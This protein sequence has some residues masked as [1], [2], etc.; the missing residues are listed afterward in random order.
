MTETKLGYSIMKR[1]SQRELL[2]PYLENSLTGDNWPDKYTIEVD[3]SPY[4]GTGDGW[5]HPSSHVLADER[6]LYY[7]LHPDFKDKLILERKTLQSALTLAMGTALHAVVQ[8]QFKMAGLITDDGIEVFSIS[9]R[10]HAR[11]SMDFRIKHPNGHKYGIEFKTQNSRSFDAEQVPK[12]QWVGQLN[13]YMDWNSLE[14]GIILVMESGFPYRMKE[15]HIVRDP[16]LLS[17]VYN[18]W[19]RVLEAIADNNPPA[20][21]CALGSKTMESCVHRNSCWLAQ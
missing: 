16:D 18:K 6:W 21:C 11:G 17:R 7:N 4:T 20:F 12:P 3:S 8:T 13:C 19:D 14:E 5:F 15:F 2:I 10:H 1:L 9:E